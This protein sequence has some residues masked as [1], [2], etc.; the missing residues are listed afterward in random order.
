MDR[1][2]EV[3]TPQSIPKHPR[4]THGEIKSWDKGLNYNSPLQSTI[5]MP[6]R[7]KL[8]TLAKLKVLWPHPTLQE[9][10]RDTNIQALAQIFIVG[11]LV[12]VI[13]MVIIM[14][15]ELRGGS[16]LL[17]LIKGWLRP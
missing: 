8:T 16:W 12:I 4:D 5:E 11:A 13:A 7:L 2:V 15:D 6:L 17:P 9:R 3:V 14:I 10:G 1:Q